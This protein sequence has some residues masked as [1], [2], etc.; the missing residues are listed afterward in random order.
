M[1]RNRGPF[2]IRSGD[3][4]AHYVGNDSYDACIM[5][6]VIRKF[7]VRSPL[8]HILRAHSIGRWSTTVCRV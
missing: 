2:G 3:T 1:P 6:G 7:K 4:A 8:L 5:K